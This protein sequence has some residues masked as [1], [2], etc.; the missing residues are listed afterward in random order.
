MRDYTSIAIINKRFKNHAKYKLKHSAWHIRRKICF[1][2]TRKYDTILL[3]LS[4]LVIKKR[5]AWLL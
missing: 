4:K 5:L 2:H 1:F 3:S